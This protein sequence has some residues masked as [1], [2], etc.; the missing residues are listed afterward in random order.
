VREEI[1]D[2]NFKNRPKITTLLREYKDLKFEEEGQPCYRVP[3]SGNIIVSDISTAG[4]GERFLTLRMDIKGN[5]GE[6]I[7]HLKY[8][9]I[10]KSV[11]IK[12]NG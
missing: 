10:Y 9:Y 7:L 8:I 5:C 4:G 6:Q 1:E 2:S 12:N 11:G 3:L